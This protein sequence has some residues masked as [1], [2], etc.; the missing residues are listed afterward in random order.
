MVNGTVVGGNQIP[1]LRNTLQG[2]KKTY[3]NKKIN[4]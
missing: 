2:E 3:M 1:M 4:E